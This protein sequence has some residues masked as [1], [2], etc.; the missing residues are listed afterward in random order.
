M[1]HIVFNGAK[2]MIYSLLFTL[3]RLAVD[4]GTVTTKA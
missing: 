1:K 2:K 4:V 3:K